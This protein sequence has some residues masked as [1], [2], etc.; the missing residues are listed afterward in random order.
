MHVAE[1]QIDDH[2]IYAAA[3]A[4]DGPLPASEAFHAAVVVVRVIAGS[5]GR[6]EVFRDECLEDGKV[7]PDPD[8]ALRF[9]LAVGEE[10]IRAQAWLAEQMLEQ[11]AAAATSSRRAA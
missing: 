4:V 8:Q 11:R 5:C 2:R 7:W 10:A 9:A 3:I 1:Q 6:E